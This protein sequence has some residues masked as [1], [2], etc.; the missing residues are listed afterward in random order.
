[1]IRP[2]DEYVLNELGGGSIHF[3]GNGGH[4]IDSILQIKSNKGLDFGDPDLIDI[5][6]IYNKCASRKIPIMNIVA[7]PEDIL[8]G[9]VVE[10]Y[11]TGAVVTCQVDTITQAKQLTH[12][13]YKTSKRGVAH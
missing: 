12:K 10:K 5:E 4:Q 8:S 11:P 3:C 9:Q 2:H 7:S 1:M 6:A 13:Y